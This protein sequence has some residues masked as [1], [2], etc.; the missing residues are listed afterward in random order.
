LAA[1]VNW[2]L[3][4]AHFPRIYSSVGR[5]VS[6]CEEDRQL[7]L[8]LA[9]HGKVDVI[10]NGVDCS[11]YTPDIRQRTGPPRILFTSTSVPRNVT[12][13]RQFAHKV[14]PLIQHELPKVELVVAG[15]FRLEAQI[16]FKKYDNIRFTGRVVDM[17]PYFNQSDVFI[18]P[19]KET[20]GSKLKIAEAMAMGMAIVSTSQGI[21]GFSLIDEESVLIAYN[22][23]QFATHVVKLLRN[24]KLREQLGK[25]ARN[26]ALITIDW[27]VLGKRL[28]KIIEETLETFK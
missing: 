11:Y 15:N 16:E 5:V 25:A 12:A 23:E 9:P 14:L 22:N 7:T 3:A 1:I 26:V 18:A 13:L 27:Q 24:H 4:A 8:S 19:F 6:V 21:R 10:E 17:R 2:R 20:H 28:I